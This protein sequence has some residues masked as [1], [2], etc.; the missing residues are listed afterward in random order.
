MSDLAWMKVYVGTETSRTIGLSPEEFGAYER[1]RRYYW[2]HRGL[3]DDDR[4]LMR[5]TGVDRERWDE[6][7]DGIYDLF[8]DGWRLPDLDREWE[9]ASVKRDRKVAAGRK[10][11]HSRWQRDGEGIADANGR[12]NA[13]ANSKTNSRTMAGPMVEPMDNQWPSAS[14]SDTVRYGESK[15]STPRAREEIDGGEIPED[16]PEDEAEGKD[17]LIRQGVWP[18]NVV[19][20]LPS[21]MAGR[22]RRSDVAAV[23]LRQRPAS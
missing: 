11:A 21:L 22:M 13:S 1:L 9:E 19:E 15:Y 3:P 18:K 5:I 16:A 17:W 6:V 2:E 20:L 23:L 10:G 7:R 14:A 8:S 4:K 12:T